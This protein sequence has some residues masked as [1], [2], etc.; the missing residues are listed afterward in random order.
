VFHHEGAH[1][2]EHH[3]QLLAGYLAFVAGLVNSAGFIL[4]GSFTSHVTGNVGRMADNLALGHHSAAAL[5]ATMIGAFFVGAFVSSMALESNWLAHR[6][7]VYGVLLLG[8]AIL[9]GVFYLLAR[10]VTAADPR[11]Q[12]SI[13][14][15]LCTAMGM[16]NSLV[17]R[18]SGAVVRTT[19]LTGVVTDLGIEAARWSRYWRSHLGRRAQIRMTMGD[20]PP[21]QPHAPKSFLLLTI[22]LTFIAGSAAGAVLAAFTGHTSMLL[23]TVLLVGGGLYAIVSGPDIVDEG[24]RK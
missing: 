12:D 5:A 8:E 23:P 22:L 14:L 9:L 7:L 15:L 4:I 16:Q 10:H 17:T 13:A 2:T 19:H 24:A 1:R 11:A 21:A 18:L 3:N 20:A 6:P